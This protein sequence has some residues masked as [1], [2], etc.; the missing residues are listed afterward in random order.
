VLLFLALDVATEVLFWLSLK[1][2]YICLYIFFLTQNS[3]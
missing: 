2:G 1:Y 3:I